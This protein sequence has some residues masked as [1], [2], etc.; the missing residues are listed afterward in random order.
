MEARMSE[1]ERL[2]TENGTRAGNRPDHPDF[3]LQSAP[4]GFEM[5]IAH[6]LVISG[7]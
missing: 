2:K 4:V 6:Q 3:S 1:D 5:G 7:A